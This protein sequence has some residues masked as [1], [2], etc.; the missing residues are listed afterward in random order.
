MLLLL[1]LLLLKSSQEYACPHDEEDHAEA[2]EYGPESGGYQLHR[3]A[4]LLFRLVN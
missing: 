3:E 1:L 2:S 4:S